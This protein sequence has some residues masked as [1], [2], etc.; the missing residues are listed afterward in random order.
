MTSNFIEMKNIIINIIIIETVN[1]D[2]KLLN[3]YQNPS[4]K[5]MKNTYFNIYF[6]E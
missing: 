2:I 5:L 4:K 6:A 1:N 3:L